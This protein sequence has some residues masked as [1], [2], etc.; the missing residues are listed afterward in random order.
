M[1]LLIN[2]ITFFRLFAGILIF[3]LVYFNNYLASLLIFMI[4][5]LSDFLDGYLARRYK[6]ESSLG[7]IIDPVADKVL[8]IFLFISITVAYKSA[9]IGF[10]SALIISREVI[11]AALRD[12][13]SRNGNSSSTRVTF[14]AKAKTSVQLFAITIYL[15][16]LL[17]NLPL[18]KIVGDILL[19]ISLIITLYTGIDYFVK[20]FKNE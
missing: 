14:L 10:V 20:S 15:I 8:I 3:L 5:S 7:E 4:A 16:A 18:M 6:M 19:I 17:L 12:Y 13:N 9:F 11:V 1:Y 2:G